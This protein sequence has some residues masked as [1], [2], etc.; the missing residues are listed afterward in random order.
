MAE[1]LGMTGLTLLMHDHCQF[2]SKHVYYS[3]IVEL[4]G[5]K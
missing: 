4:D 5:F 3:V 2:R 1:M